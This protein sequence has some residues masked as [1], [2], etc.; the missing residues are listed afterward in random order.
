MKGEEMNSFLSDVLYFKSQK[1]AKENKRSHATAQ[2]RNHLKLPQRRKFAVSVI[3]LLL[4]LD[5]FFYPTR[6]SQITQR[7]RDS[8]IIK[9]LREISRRKIRSLAGGDPDILIDRAD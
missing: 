8:I 4:K 9:D 5:V 1:V 3:L 6:S 2:S 7:L